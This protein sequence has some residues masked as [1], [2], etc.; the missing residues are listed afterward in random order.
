MLRKDIQYFIVSHYPLIRLVVK[1]QNEFFWYR[2]YVQLLYQ[3]IL[4]F[5]MPFTY[6]PHKAALIPNPKLKKRWKM[7]LW[8]IVNFLII[9]VFIYCVISEI[10]IF[11]SAEKA[12]KINPELFIVHG[13]ILVVFL[14]AIVTFYTFE[15]D[16]PGTTHMVTSAF[17]ALGIKHIGK[18]LIY[19]LN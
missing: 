1:S 19:V 18:S 3:S 6:D 17:Q 8:E 16:P 4:K 12:S 15:R 11:A 14:Q 9:I 10:K 2:L 5:D 13:F 7:P